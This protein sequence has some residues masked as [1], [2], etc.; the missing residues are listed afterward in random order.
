M[1]FSTFEILGAGRRG[2]G[3]GLRG[4]TTNIPTGC[5]PC[6]PC[7]KTW[8]GWYVGSAIGAVSLAVILVRAVAQP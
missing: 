2:G 6:P 7:E 1:K 5:P 8:V 4:S 3:R